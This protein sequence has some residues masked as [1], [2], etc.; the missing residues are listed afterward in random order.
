M[1]DVVVLGGGLAGLLVAR[2][3]RALGRDVVVVEPRTRPVRK[4][5]ESTVEIG[6]W[7]LTHT[8]GLG[9]QLAAHGWPKRGMH[10]FF[11]SGPLDGR[12][13][14]APPPHGVP[15]GV[16]LDRRALEAALLDEEPSVR[17]GWTAEGVT[18]GPPH[19][20]HL[21]RADHR[22]HLDAAW[23]I[24]ATG[25][26][27]LL[28]RQ[29]RWAVAAAH[30][31]RARWL[32]LDQV[33]A[34][35]RTAENPTLHLS[36]DR[37]W[38]WLIPQGPGRAA[39]G[40][41]GLSREVDPLEEMRSAGLPAGRVV[42]RGRGDGLSVGST[43]LIDARGV[44]LVG[45]A[46][47]FSDPLFSPGL[48]DIAFHVDAVARA[49]QQPQDVH[50]LD[51]LLRNRLAVGQ[52]LIP[53]HYAALGDVRV[54][55][56]HYVGLLAQYFR[57]FA[58]FRAGEHLDTPP[59]PV[60]AIQAYASRLGRWRPKPPTGRVHDDS[61]DIPALREVAANLDAL[62]LH[63]RWVRLVAEGDPELSAAQIADR[64]L[65]PGRRRGRGAVAEVAKAPLKR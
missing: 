27:R 49:V 37:A 3:L 21:R 4:V 48:D 6:T 30:D 9:S 54:F 55:R 50:R 26:R 8:M 16:Q 23:V 18:L 41:V 62:E 20:V 59:V 60:R 65:A 47:G 39:V 64:L 38:T 15:R 25:R 14:I 24:D 56:L 11:G 1:P 61:L 5:G 32:W 53:A 36:R 28:A 35:P 33:P 10:L 52:A 42:G 7:H 12:H 44:A 51:A 45:D 19:R 43:R 13:E 17:R 22:D 63:R 58:R 40:S 46:G 29:E 57:L 2:R 34:N 31:T